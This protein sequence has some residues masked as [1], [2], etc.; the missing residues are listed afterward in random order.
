MGKGSGNKIKFS[1]FENII[2]LITSKYYFLDYNLRLLIFNWLFLNYKLPF[3]IFNWWFLNYNKLKAEK[4]FRL[5]FKIFSHF[6][7]FIIQR[8]FWW[9]GQ[10]IFSQVVLQKN[11]SY[12]LSAR[13]VF[14]CVQRNV[15]TYFFRLH[16]CSSMDFVIR[17]LSFSTNFSIIFFEVLHPSLLRRSKKLYFY[18]SLL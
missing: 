5:N 15:D 4:Y 16:F 17:S 1:K 6:F 3:L 2:K 11:F 9:L 14:L 13:F 18:L 8:I 12:S 10:C 7:K